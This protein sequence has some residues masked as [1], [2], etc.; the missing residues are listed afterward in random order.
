VTESF[1]HPAPPASKEP[2]PPLTAR[3]PRPKAIRLRKSAVTALVIG[4]AGLLS[5][6]LAWAFIVKPEMRAEAREQKRET[7]DT[8]QP[9]TVRAGEV[10][11]DQ[12]ASYDRL[13][14]PEDRLPEPRGFGADAPEGT[15]AIDPQPQPVR[16]YA[17]V[18]EPR[19]APPTSYD[20]PLQ[21]EP[22]RSPAQSAA[23]QAAGSGLFFGG[24]EARPAAPQTTSAPQV[25]LRQDYGAV[26]GGHALLAPLSPYELKA[27]AFIPGA[28]VTAVDTS[29]PGP[30]V[31]AVT[32]NVFDTAT[33]R[34]LLVPQGT[35][36]IGR[37]GG[38]SRYGDKR[39]FLVW[40]RLIL[41]NGKSLILTEEAGVDAQGAVGVRGR[42]D[43]R[44]LQLSA[45]AL[46]A[47]AITTLGELARG[48]SDDDRSLLGSAGD[49]ASIEAAQVGGR[50]IDREL[51][52]RP[53]IHVRAGS[54]VR[55]LLTR[56]LILEPY[57][58]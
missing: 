56:D 24:T 47:G 14:A 36:L 5:G 9:G 58:P 46:F 19:Y 31:A 41:P 25:A 30:V 57:R 32:Q 39:A 50:L 38:E 7:R 40:D 4:A 1:T 20:A 8:G 28:L 23:T 49:A 27:G 44:L 37:N 45:A 51:E 52:V 42:A 55:V 16:A 12:P 11:T 10:I 18:S 15:E 21:R 22:R 17:R 3:A 6:S 2:P 34:I 29:R 53:S 48:G 43:R 33:G 26:Y 35:K 13:G 54:T